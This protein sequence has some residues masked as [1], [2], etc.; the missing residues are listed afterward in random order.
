VEFFIF[1]SSAL[2]IVRGGRSETSADG[3]GERC[4]CLDG[5]EDVTKEKLSC[6]VRLLASTLNALR[7]T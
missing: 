7:E 3:E 2:P 6:V 4:K 1:N 5:V